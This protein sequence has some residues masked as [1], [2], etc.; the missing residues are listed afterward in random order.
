MVVKDDYFQF[1]NDLE[2]FLVTDFDTSKGI[3]HI[4]F[5]SDSVEQLHA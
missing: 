2:E 5:R 1:F 3:V 4:E